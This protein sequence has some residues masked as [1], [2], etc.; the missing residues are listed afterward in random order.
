M[1]DE[2]VPT[3]ASPKS[4]ADVPWDER[5]IPWRIPASPELRLEDLDGP[6][7]LRFNLGERGCIHPVRVPVRD[8][9]E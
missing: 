3:R 9:V 5:E 6:R 2:G 8:I 1:P 4:P 7:D